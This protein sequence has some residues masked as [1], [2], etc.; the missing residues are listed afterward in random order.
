MVFTSQ[1]KHVVAKFLD[2]KMIDSKIVMGQVQDFQILL[3]DILS[4]GMTLTGTFQ[5]AAMIEKFP[6]GW[7]DFKN[8]IKHKQ[9]EMSV[10]E[11]V[12]WDLLKTH[13]FPRTRELPQFPISPKPLRAF[14]SY[15]SSVPVFKMSKFGDSFRNTLN[16]QMNEHLKLFSSI[17]VL[18][19]DHK[20]DFLGY[21]VDMLHSCSF[22]VT[23]VDHAGAALKLLSKKKSEFDLVLID[24]GMRDVDVHT[25]LSLTKNMDVLTIVMSEQDDDAFLIEALMGGAFLVL[26]RPLTI[27]AVRHMRQDIIRERM[28]KHVENSKNK[29][30]ILKAKT[31][32]VTT[33]EN[34][35]KRK[36]RNEPMKQVSRP[37]Y[38]SSQDDDDDDD[39]H[40]TK[41][42]LCIEWT[43]ELHQKFL[44]AI[45]E[46]GEGRCFPKEILHLMDVPGLT[47]MQVASHLQKCRKEKSKSRNNR[48]TPASSTSST[49]SSNGSPLEVSERKFG[50][51]PI[52][53]PNQKVQ[54]DRNTVIGINLLIN[55][56][57][58]DEN[59]NHKNDQ[60]Y[61]CLPM[62]NGFNQKNIAQPPHDVMFPLHNSIQ[63]EGIGTRINKPTNNYFLQAISGS[64]DAGHGG[65]DPYNFSRQTSD[66]FPDYLKDIDGNG[67]ND[68]LIS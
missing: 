21:V 27:D 63:Y 59:E 29:N 38:Q 49:L 3:H 36:E 66:D 65:L 35:N 58:T 24:S 54:E 5:V 40:S 28:H 42:K 22:E 61:R 10:V 13:I 44:D 19:V 51:M 56:W 7:T 39:D 62:M 25:F 43:R 30:M 53:H 26:K 4:E 55:G 9:K 68:D 31:Q 60:A 37:N 47:R 8:Y 34:S 23:C 2:F 46:L 32:A 16:N 67:P 33:P 48:R 15:I 6:P 52:I 18:V 50:C 20:M 57:Q 45:S 17:K 12:S 14:N 64:H 1:Q 11:F 41:K